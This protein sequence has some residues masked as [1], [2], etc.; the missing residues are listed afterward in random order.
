MNIQALEVDVDHVHI[1][2][3]VPPQR[4]VAIYQG[5]AGILLKSNYLA[6]G[7]L[8]AA[9]ME[10]VQVVTPEHIRSIASR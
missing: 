5:S 10:K 2:I 6:K 4:S 1:Y 7:G 9:A 3:D 8:V